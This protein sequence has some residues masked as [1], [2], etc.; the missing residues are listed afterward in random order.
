MHRDRLEIVH[1]HFRFRVRSNRCRAARERSCRHRSPDRR[2]SGAR[3]HS[4]RIRSRSGRMEY[5]RHRCMVPQYL[6]PSS[7]RARRSRGC[8][9]P[10][11]GH[12]AA[13]LKISGCAIAEMAKTPTLGACLA[14]AIATFLMTLPAVAA[15]CADTAASSL[16]VTCCGLNERCSFPTRIQ[17]T[18]DPGRLCGAAPAFSPQSEGSS[19]YMTCYDAASITADENSG[20]RQIGNFFAERLQ[21]SSG[22]CQATQLQLQQLQLL[23]APTPQGAAFGRGLVCE[24]ATTS[25][26]NGRLKGIVY[27]TK[28][29]P[30]SSSSG[31]MPGVQTAFP[32]PSQGQSTTFSSTIS[33]SD[34]GGGGDARSSGAAVSVLPVTP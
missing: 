9:V 5:A 21:A 7:T 2:N 4:C 1:A 26:S 8:P 22:T 23:Q 11:Q 30:P 16:M 12:L 20:L 28:S 13:A 34:G 10:P 18:P 6:L 32:A 17:I 25:A 14:A 3:Y 24:C 29:T 19:F 27:F 15:S 33:S 31:A